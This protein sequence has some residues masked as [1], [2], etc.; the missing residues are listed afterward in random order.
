[1]TT[2]R[3][4][5]SPTRAA[6][7]EATRQA[8]LDAFRDQ[9]LEPGREALSPTDAASAAGCSVRTVH[10][11]FPTKES[12][13]VALAESLEH[14]LWAEPVRPPETADDLPDHF[15]RIHEKALGDPLA[16]A[17]IK[18]G[19]AEW[20]EV[21]ARRRADRLEAVRRT[22]AEIGAP[23]APTAQATAAILALAGAEVSLTM[24]DELGLDAGEIPDAL[25]YAVGA[26]VS[27]LRRTADPG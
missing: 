26:I 1:M 19:G 2:T 7:A 24:R 10:G 13:V 27:D 8:I 22:I 25:A 16:A 9:L 14:E 15:R 11:Y 17:L 23:A 18:H 12:R 21:R 5:R 6:Q 20:E 4:Y 3:R